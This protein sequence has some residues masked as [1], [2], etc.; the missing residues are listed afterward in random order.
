LAP[1]GLQHMHPINLQRVQPTDVLQTKP[2]L[3]W[4][5]G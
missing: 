1:R 5:I 2:S 3:S 4:F